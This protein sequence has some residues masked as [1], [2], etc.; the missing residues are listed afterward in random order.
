MQLHDYALELLGLAAADEYVIEKLIDDTQASDSIIGFHCQQAVE[1][2]MS[3]GRVHNLEYLMRLV[4][5]TGD[6]LP[7]SLAELDIL[8]PFAVT[9]RYQASDELI[10][11]D[12]RHVRSL[13][14]E[15]RRWVEKRVLG[16]EVGD[17]Q[18]NPS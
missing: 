2:C 1:K 12:R 15:L 5:D 3:F 17:N 11:L 13:V 7:G 8:N 9:L 6:C 4:N 14:I 16:S 10:S 18:G